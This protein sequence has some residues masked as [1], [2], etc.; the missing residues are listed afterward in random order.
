MKRETINKKIEEENQSFLF[1]ISSLQWLLGFSLIELVIVMGILGLVSGSTFVFLSNILRGSN[2]AKISGEIKQ[3]GQTI[4]DSVDRQIRNSVSAAKLTPPP[5]GAVSAIELALADNSFLYLVC[6]DS[7][8]SPKTNGWIG[9]VNT[10]L[11]SP[12]ASSAGYSTL[13]NQ[14]VSSGVDVDC[15]PATFGVNGLPS[16]PF[17]QV[18]SV[19]FTINQGIGSPTR[20]DFMANAK[21]KTTISLRKYSL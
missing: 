14:D 10:A 21:F 3:N 12:P 5:A 6:F 4:L 9:I 15:N 2:Q 17:P 20:V 16:D 1:K 19:D 8:S 13:T 18:V 11:A 7:I